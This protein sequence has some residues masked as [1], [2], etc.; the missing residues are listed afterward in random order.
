MS[1]LRG[2]WS[3]S[4]AKAAFGVSLH[5]WVCAGR[6]RRKRNLQDLQAVCA[7][8]ADRFGSRP[9]RAAQVP[10]SVRSRYG[11]FEKLT[12]LVTSPGRLGVD[13]APAQDLLHPT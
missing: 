8:D 4:R 2:A 13:G 10:R 11:S 12:P 1:A 9:G 5:G 6:R 3:E 7:A